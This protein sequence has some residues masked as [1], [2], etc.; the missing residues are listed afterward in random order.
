M[1]YEDVC[2][3]YFP[4]HM[5]SNHTVFHDA[6]FGGYVEDISLASYVSFFEKSMQADMKQN[7]PEWEEEEKEE[8]GVRNFLHET[9]DVV[10][11]GGEA[12]FMVQ[13]ARDSGR[14]FTLSHQ[15]QVT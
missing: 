10:N 3:R 2:C 7:Y 6:V 1:Y 9:H 12:G 4:Q 13:V 14:H 11:L 8:V 5:S 15:K